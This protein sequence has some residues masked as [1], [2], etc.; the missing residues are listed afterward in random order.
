MQKK[1]KDDYLTWTKDIYV[2]KET[3]NTAICAP[4]YIFHPWLPILRV[5]PREFVAWEMAMIPLM[6]SL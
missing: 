4:S 6:P 2:K 5:L 1:Q 3:R